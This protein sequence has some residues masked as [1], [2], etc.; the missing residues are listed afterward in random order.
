MHRWNQKFYLPYYMQQISFTSEMKMPMLYLK[1]KTCDE[2]FLSGID[3][4]EKNFEKVK[5]KGYH[6]CPK[7]HAHKY[8]KKDYYFKEITSTC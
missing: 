4:D 2:E 5:F 7:W 3:I 6:I 8:D 1:C